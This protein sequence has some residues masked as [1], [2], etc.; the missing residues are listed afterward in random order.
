LP[1]V[2][3]RMLIFQSDSLRAIIYHCIRK[4]LRPGRALRCFIDS[5]RLTRLPGLE[6]RKTG[7]SEAP[8][9]RPAK[10]VAPRSTEIQREPKIAVPNHVPPP[11]SN[12]ATF[13]KIE[14]VSL[15]DRV[16]DAL[17]DSFLRGQFS[18]GDAIV[19]SRD[20][21]QVDGA[22]L[23]I[24]CRGERRAPDRVHGQGTS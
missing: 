13:E 6:K 22:A 12:A 24:C 1:G 14:P 18:P 15:T 11:R 19:E 21:R 2:P 7:S 4:R 23:R 8:L 9:P 20:P 10:K 17:R 3:P 5:R 16:V